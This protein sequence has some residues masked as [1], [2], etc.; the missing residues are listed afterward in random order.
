MLLCPVCNSIFVAD[1]Y[2]GDECPCC[3]I[4]ILI[5]YNTDIIKNTMETAEEESMYEQLLKQN[6]RTS[7]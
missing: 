1:V 7:S 4:G 5:P 6:S 3:T 2:E